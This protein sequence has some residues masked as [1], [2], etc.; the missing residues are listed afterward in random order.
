M[1]YIRLQKDKDYKKNILLRSKIIQLIRSFFDQKEFLE[2]ETPLITPYPAM[3]TNLH[4]LQTQ[5]YNHQKNVFTGH[6]ITSPEY[7]MKKVLV[8]GFDKIYQMSKV[9][10]NQE[11]FGGH[12]NPEFTM[13]EWYRAHADYNDI[14]EDTLGLIQFIAQSLDKMSIKVGD[15]IIELDSIEILTVEEAFKRFCHINIREYIDKKDLFAELLVERGYT[16]SA[17]DTWDDLYFK[18]FLNEIEPYLGQ[19]CVTV[20]KDYP[21]TQ[22]ALAQLKEGDSLFA[23][24]FEVYIGGIELCNGFSELTDGDEQLRRFQEEQKT[25]EKE[26]GVKKEIDMSFINA[27]QLGMPKSGGV[28]LGVDRL[29]MLFCES[30]NIEDVL[31]FPAKEMFN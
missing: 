1:S 6:L 22:G 13:I 10:R 2:V 31:L 16:I 5:I 12:H 21:Y 14:I 8:G 28:A 24:R 30:E 18:I 23:E 3:E 9:F 7:A 20:L 25:Y 11:S 19:N 27:L 26:Y 4:T 29:V 15:S 17:D